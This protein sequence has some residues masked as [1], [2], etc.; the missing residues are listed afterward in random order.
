[1]GQVGGQ[2][3]K[4]YGVIFTGDRHDFHYVNKHT[5]NQMYRWLSDQDINF[6]IR[7]RI[8]DMVW[9]DVSLSVCAFEQS[10]TIIGWNL[11]FESEADRNM[12]LAISAFG[13]FFTP[14]NDKGLINML[15]HISKLEQAKN[16][17]LLNEH[18]IKGD[19]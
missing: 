7:N 6:S 16:F 1:M 8:E 11:W 2:K 5:T 9:G 12:F 3:N 17:A 15:T 18:T 10:K 4:P 13:R 14:V 19:Q